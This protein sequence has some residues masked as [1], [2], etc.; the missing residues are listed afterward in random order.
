MERDVL[1]IH[2]LLHHLVLLSLFFCLLV[3]SWSFLLFMDKLE[4]VEGKFHWQ[5]RLSSLVAQRLKRLPAMWET[6]VQSLG[7]ENPLEKEMATHSSILAWRIPWTEE[8][9]GLQS[10]GSQR[11]GHD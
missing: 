2:L 3:F 7:W 4:A 8:P 10:T 9:G 1:H 5:L 6:R 11:V